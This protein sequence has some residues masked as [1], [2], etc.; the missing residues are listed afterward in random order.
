MRLFLFLICHKIYGRNRVQLKTSS[1]QIFFFKVEIFHEND[2]KSL[3]F[4]PE[5]CSPEP[6]SE[7]FKEEIETRKEELSFSF[8][9]N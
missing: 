9:E 6:I 4:K 2:K 1:S 8:F 7:S 3:F 5:Q